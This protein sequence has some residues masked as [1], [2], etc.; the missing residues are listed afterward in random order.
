MV[1]LQHFLAAVGSIAAAQ[2][3][4]QHVYPYELLGL[5]KSCFLAVNA[6]IQGCAELLASHVSFTSGEY[7]DVLFASSYSDSSHDMACSDCR[8]K[9]RRHQLESPFRYDEES[10]ASF[11]AE[12]AACGVYGY[13]VSKPGAHA[14][15]P[16]GTCRPRATEYRFAA[17]IVTA[18]DNCHKVSKYN[19]V[20][21]YSLLSLNGLWRECDTLTVGSTLYLP[22]PCDVQPEFR[23]PWGQEPPLAPGTLEGCHEYARGFRVAG[24]KR[25]T[26]CKV[27]ASVSRVQ[28]ADLLEWNPS[29]DADDCYLDPDLRYCV[30]KTP[31]PEEEDED[32]I[33]TW[34]YCLFDVKEHE[35]MPKTDPDCRCFNVVTY[36]P[37][38][39]TTCEELAE[40]VE[41]SVDLLLALN[42]WL[43]RETCAADLVAGMSEPYEERYFCL[44]NGDLSLEAS[45]LF[46]PALV[47]IYQR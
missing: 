32:N 17:H 3:L 44:A 30:Q 43:S 15:K 20:S 5:T 36:D 24:Q 46:P 19:D 25:H 33:S 1:R 14:V 27:E 28:I 9:T 10:A 23:Y 38:Y 2:Q 6:T 11:A 42:G 34:S 7:C 29:L 8:F 4:P 35:I 16:A 41:I 37:D 26:T 31:V 13:Y 47:L 22:L 39:E 12:K 18:A 21:T 45:L 40:D